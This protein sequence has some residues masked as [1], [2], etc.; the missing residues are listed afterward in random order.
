MISARP[1]PPESDRICHPDRDLFAGSERHLPRE[2]SVFLL[3]GRR[4]LDLDVGDLD[5]RVRGGRDAVLDADRARVLPEALERDEVLIPY[6]CSSSG[7]P[8][9]DALSFSSLCETFTLWSM[10]RCT[11]KVCSGATP[12]MA[13]RPTKVDTRFD[14]PGGVVSTYTSATPGRSGTA[15]EFSNVPSRNTRSERLGTAWRD[16]VPPSRSRAMRARFGS[17]PLSR[18]SGILIWRF[19][20]ELARRY[21]RLS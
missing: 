10:P 14:A 1:D 20:R 4:R 6:L 11:A 21:S 18:S 16:T 2:Q 19:A 13:S 7:P 12:T 15:R 9:R 17:A 3:L 8:S 5:V